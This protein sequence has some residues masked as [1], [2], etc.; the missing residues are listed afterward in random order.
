MLHNLA[1]STE[2][3]EPSE[4]RPG[5]GNCP[6]EPDSSSPWFSPVPPPLFDK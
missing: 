4:P 1:Q 2:W 5:Q 3:S 6:L